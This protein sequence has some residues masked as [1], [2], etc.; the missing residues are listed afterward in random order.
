MENDEEKD[1]KRQEELS[2]ED[3][4]QASVKSIAEIIPAFLE[5]N[6]NLGHEYYRDNIFKLIG[7][8]FTEPMKFISPKVAIE[9]LKSILA[10]YLLTRFAYGDF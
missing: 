6:P 3:T 9:I 8:N 7:E 10:L 4:L 5:N 1:Q 2:W